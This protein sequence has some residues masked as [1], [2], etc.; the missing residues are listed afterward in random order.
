MFRRFSRH[1]RFTRWLLLSSGL[2]I[3]LT[4]VPSSASQ[5]SLTVRRHGS[6]NVTSI[7]SRRYSSR[8]RF[9]PAYRS[10]LYY[11]L[12]LP[13]RYGYGH[14][15][16][17]NSGTVYRGYYGSWSNWPYG[18]LYSRYGL[19]YR[20][21]FYPSLSYY[22]LRPYQPYS[23]LYVPYALPGYVYPRINTFSFYG[24]SIAWDSRPLR[25]PLDSGCC[26][27]YGLAP[28]CK[29]RIVCS[30][31]YYAYYYPGCQRV[32]ACN[33]ATGNASQPMPQ[34]TQP[35]EPQ[36]DK[37]LPQ[38][39]DPQKPPTKTPAGQT[40]QP[41]PPQPGNSRSVPSQSVGPRIITPRLTPP[42]VVISDLANRQSPT[43][44]PVK[45]ADLNVTFRPTVLSSPSALKPRLVIPQ[46]RLR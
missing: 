37:P 31:P 17:F 21:M 13:Y 38:R 7:S 32:C 25:L 30:R 8:R 4:A 26:D 45:T 42:E 22:S 39:A 14:M 16:P 33:D 19:G 28:Q 15:R 43:S 36:P 18:G 34:P 46:Q 5:R 11:S 35:I 20:S 23:R 12:R 6:S 44:V 2:S 3:V 1:A 27:R 10:S 24:P 9:N 41:M 40:P 29:T